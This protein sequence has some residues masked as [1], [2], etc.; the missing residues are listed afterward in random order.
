MLIL[1]STARNSSSR[2][3]LGPGCAW[4]HRGV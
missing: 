2:N 1:D 4:W 3:G